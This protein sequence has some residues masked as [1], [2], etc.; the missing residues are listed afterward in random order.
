M[1]YVW[2]TRRINGTVSSRNK[3]I[4][5]D[6]IVDLESRIIELKETLKRNI[7][8]KSLGTDSLVGFNGADNPNETGYGVVEFKIIKVD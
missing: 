5:I 4:A 2:E 8:L 1:P 3:A 7:V 6:R